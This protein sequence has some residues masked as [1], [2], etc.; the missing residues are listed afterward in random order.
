MNQTEVILDLLT[1]QQNYVLGLY[2]ELS[3]Q[4]GPHLLTNIQ[5]YDDGSVGLYLE[6]F[7]TF[8]ELIEEGRMNDQNF[9]FFLIRLEE[10]IKQ[11]HQDYLHGSLSPTSVGLCTVR[12]LDSG[13]RDQICFLDFE[14]SYRIKDLENGIPDYLINYLEET[15]GILVTEVQEYIEVLKPLDLSVLQSVQNY[16][17]ANG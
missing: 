10:K 6:N 1:D 4:F 17:E 13:T 9:E 2:R 15:Y 7:R 3:S 8:D 16:Y 12:S 11:F 14:Y 5:E